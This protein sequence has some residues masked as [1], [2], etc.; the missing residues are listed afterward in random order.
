MRLGIF[1][2]V[3]SWLFQ[4]FLARN[5]QF[6]AAFRPAACQNLTAIS[7]LHT[8]AE[9]VYALAAALMGLE[10]TFHYACF[11]TNPEFGFFSM[12]QSPYC[13]L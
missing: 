13:C 7:G 11:L 2:L 9:T 5:S 10:C 6:L 4:S 1:L 12:P 8:L 3:V